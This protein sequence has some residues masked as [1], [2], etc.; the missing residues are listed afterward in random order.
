VLT[1]LIP[2]KVERLYL[3]VLNPFV[4]MIS[5]LN[6]NPNFFTIL[7][8]VIGI[9]AGYFYG[10]GEFVLAGIFTLLTGIVDTIDGRVARATNRV[11][12]FGAL[13]DST[14]DRYAEVIIFFGIGFYLIKNGFY[15]TSIAAVFAIGGSMMVSYV[16]A[17]AEGLGFECNI[18]FMRRAER[19]TLLGFG[20]FFYFLHSHFVMALSYIF[21]GLKIEI[22]EYP[23]MPLSISIYIMAVLANIT[24]FQRLFYVWKRSKFIEVPK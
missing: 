11:T 9:F 19:I 2:K 4:R 5:Y 1:N 23:P 22:T 10:M 8:L 7:S 14:I 12:K 15:I 24:A 13:F 17:R 21:E 3:I 20:A 16:R 6:P 18:G